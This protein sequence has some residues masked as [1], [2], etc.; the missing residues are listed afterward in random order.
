MA[1]LAAFE[2][3]V[4]LVIE[5]LENESFKREIHMLIGIQD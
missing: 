2:P 5:R 3:M 4:Y 1:V